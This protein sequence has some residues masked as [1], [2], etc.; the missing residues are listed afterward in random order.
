MRRVGMAERSNGMAG[1]RIV[2]QCDGRAVK[3]EA[4]QRQS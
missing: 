1:P 4:A 2:Q 3:S